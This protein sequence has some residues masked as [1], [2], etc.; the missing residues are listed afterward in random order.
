MAGV[1]FYELTSLCWTYKDTIVAGLRTIARETFT[2][3]F[4]KRA[5][6]MCLCQALFWGARANARAHTLQLEMTQGAARGSRARVNMFYINVQPMNPR[7]FYTNR[8]AIIP[9]PLT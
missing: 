6:R 7:V 4:H 1:L 2:F 8:Y 9:Y 5:S 3:P